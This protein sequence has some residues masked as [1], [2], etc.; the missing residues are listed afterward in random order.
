[1][2]WRLRLDLSSGR[3]LKLYVLRSYQE[4]RE[5]AASLLGEVETLAVAE[6]EHFDW[7]ETCR[8]EIPMPYATGYCAN[9]ARWLVDGDMRCTFH[10]NRLP[11][12]NA[13]G[14]V[15]LIARGS[16]SCGQLGYEMPREWM[17]VRLADVLMA[18]MAARRPTEGS[19]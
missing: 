2:I 11:E 9:T 19:H 16:R 3:T 15:P 14:V 6:P 5:L 10:R 8:H 4:A 18:K 1:M 13:R 7:R 17:P 12:P